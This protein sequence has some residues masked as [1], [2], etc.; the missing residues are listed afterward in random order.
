M[1]INSVNFYNQS[2]NARKNSSSTNRKRP[3]IVAK[4]VCPV[5]FDSYGNVNIT[6]GLRFR[7]YLKNI[8][9]TITDKLFFNR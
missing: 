5:E 6:L 8:Y 9:F 3:L 7:I 2:L 1:R 4:I